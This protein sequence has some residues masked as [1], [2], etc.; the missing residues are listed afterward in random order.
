MPATTAAGLLAVVGVFDLFGTIASGWLTDR[1]DPRGLLLVPYAARAVAVHRQFLA[2]D[3]VPGWVFIVF[4][5]LDWVATVPPTVALLPPTS[6]SPTQASSSAG[7]MPRT[8]SAPAS[9]P[10]HRL[11]PDGVDGTTDEPGP[12]PASS[13]RRR[14]R[15]AHHPRRARDLAESGLHTPAPE[16]LDDAEEMTFT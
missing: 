15:R 11:D 13:P 10:L 1:M 14:L 5:G 12:A 6:G 4:Y 3:V 9:A 8:W 7:R 16:E 2:P